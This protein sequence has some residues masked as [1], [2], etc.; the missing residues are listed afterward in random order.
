MGVHLAR[1]VEEEACVEKCME[2]DLGAVEED[3]LGST[4]EADVGRGLQENL[5][6]GTAANL[7]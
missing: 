3:S 6:A 7:G 1:F 4:Q 2:E 5:E